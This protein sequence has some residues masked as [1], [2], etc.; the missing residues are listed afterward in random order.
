MGLTDIDDRALRLA[1]SELERV[2]LEVPG[3]RDVFTAVLDVTDAA[4][5]ARVAKEF[6]A[7]KRIDA[8]FNSAGLLAIGLFKDL[9]LER[10]TKQV[11]VNVDGVVNMTYAALPH[12]VRDGEGG[13]VVTMAS[14]SAVAGIPNHAVY[15]ATKAFVYSLTEALA[16]EFAPLN[17]H[18]GD[19]SVG[20]VDTH[21]VQS[22]ENRNTTLLDQ[23]T[24]LFIR[25]R[26]VALR[27]WDAVHQC[28]LEREHF[29]VEWAS[30]AAFKLVALFRALGMRWGMR[31]IGAVSMPKDKA[32]AARL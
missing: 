19:V 17:I 21:M 20:Y 28:R 9:P 31:I 2:P 13:R 30:A 23:P 32:A 24:S 27:V 12:L 8:L 18:V 10:Q 14:Q 6:G 5:C 25:P 26:D 1:A 22:Q 3:A 15:A 11:R 29:Y 4:A 16:I 7:S